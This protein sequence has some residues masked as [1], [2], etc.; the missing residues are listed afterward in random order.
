MRRT[1]T[2]KRVSRREI[3]EPVTDTL[4]ARA[5]PQDRCSEPVSGRGD[6]SESARRRGPRLF[7]VSL[8][9]AVDVRFFAGTAFCRRS[10]EAHRLLKCLL[11]AWP[12]RAVPGDFM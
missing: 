12:E 2:L 9:H 8:G 10:D 6:G 11:T 7:G 1:A 3:A 5:G 4:L